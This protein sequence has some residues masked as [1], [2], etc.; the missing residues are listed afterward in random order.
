MS[1]KKTPTLPKEV[2]EKYESTIVPCVVIISKPA[3]IAGRYDLTEISLSNAEKL[4]KAGKYL[5]AIEAS[6][7]VKK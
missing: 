4:S 7:E 2:A 6:K 1:E 5:K 3:E